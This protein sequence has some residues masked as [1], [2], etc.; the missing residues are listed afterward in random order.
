M[1]S[2]Y[3]ISFIS[4]GGIKSVNPS[5]FFQIN[6]GKDGGSEAPNE[7]NSANIDGLAKSRF[8]AIFVVTSQ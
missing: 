6:P 1:Y 5:L 7:N 8:S 3:R 4:I 2:H